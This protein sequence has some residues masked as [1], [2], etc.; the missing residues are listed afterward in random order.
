MDMYTGRYECH[1]TSLLVHT[2]HVQYEVG[3]EG[4]Y[5]YSTMYLAALPAAP[6]LPSTMLY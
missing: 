4:C 5:S 2:V 1:G 6:L 3:S